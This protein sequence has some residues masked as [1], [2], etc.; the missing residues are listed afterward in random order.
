MKV[1]ES[2]LLAQFFNTI[3]SYLFTECI[4]DQ[5][6]NDRTSEHEGP[7]ASYKGFSGILTSKTIKCIYLIVISMEYCPIVGNT[8]HRDTAQRR[9]GKFIS[10][11][12]STV[13]GSGS[14][15]YP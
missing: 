12:L 5:F 13:R 15:N 3:R 7:I 8:L 1:I 11:E 14:S 10:D 4:Q 9:N 6:L 2:H